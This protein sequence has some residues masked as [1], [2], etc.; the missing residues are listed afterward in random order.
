MT[1]E[2]AVVAVATE[3]P[4]GARVGEPARAEAAAGMAAPTAAAEA[5][6]EAMEVVATLGA[7]EPPAREP[8]QGG[9]QSL[10]ERR[11]RGHTS[12]GAYG[13]GRCSS[14]E[15]DRQGAG[16]E[17]DSGGGGDARRSGAAGKGGHGHLSRGGHRGHRD[18]HAEAATGL[19]ASAP[20][21]IADRTPTSLSGC[22]E[23]SGAFSFRP[24][25]HG[26]QP[27]KARVFKCCPR[28]NFRER[29]CRR[30]CGGKANLL[31]EKTVR[32]DA[33]QGYLSHLN[34]PFF[35]LGKPVGSRA[36]A[37]SYHQVLPVCILML[38][39][40]RNSEGLRS[41]AWVPGWD[42][43][44]RRSFER[45]ITSDK[46]TT[47]PLTTLMHFCLGQVSRVLRDGASGPEAFALVLRLLNG[48]FDRVDSE[49]G[50]EVTHF[51]R[52]ERDAF[53]R[54]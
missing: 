37:H 52:A 21:E 32:N 22:E 45:A 41:A 6:E 18:I 54:F 27:R 26:R 15:D 29:S 7:A 46:P 35:L 13:A 16:C 11:H 39:D 49:A 51:W 12:S 3:A 17:G 36:R 53:L 20:P 47:S 10:L 28:S 19:A 9:A 33:S 1:V 48:H 50:Y 38:Y 31:R 40:E 2:E 8:G 23:A 42:Y 43:P 4:P 5:E 14:S 44:L 25:H 30:G 24:S 34:S